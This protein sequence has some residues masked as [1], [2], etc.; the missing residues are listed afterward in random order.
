MPNFYYVLSYCVC[1]DCVSS[2]GTCAE[3]LCEKKILFFFQINRMNRK[4][5]LALLLTKAQT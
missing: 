1:I 3:G 4:V 2:L 5:L